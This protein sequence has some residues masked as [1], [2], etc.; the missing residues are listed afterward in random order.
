MN[1]TSTTIERF[2]PT[3]W[4]VKPLKE[5]AAFEKG[6]VVATQP[7]SGTGLI[8]YIGADS[9]GGSFTQ[10]T[11]DTAATMCE[12]SDVLM[13]WDGERSGLCANRLKGAIGSTVARLRPRGGVNGRFLY[14]QLAQHFDWIQA[15]RTGTGVPHVPKDLATLLYVSLPNDETEQARIALV[16]DT[17]DEAIAKTEAV[18]A[19]L[20]QVRAGLL[21]DLL[22]R[23]LDAHGQLR[24]PIAHPEQFQDSPLGRIPKEWKT[25]LLGQIST[26]QTGDK[27]T[28]DRVD[29]GLYPFYVRSDV[30]E[31]LNSFTFDCEAILTAGDGVGVGKVIHYATG[32]FD[33]HQRVYCIHSFPAHVC[34]RFLYYYFKENFGRRVAGMSA[35]NSVDSV[36]MNMI[37]DMPV[38]VPP[39]PEQETIANVLADADMCI[40]R[41]GAELTKL[42][43]LK[44]GLMTDLLTGRVRVPATIEL[45]AA[46]ANGAPSNQPGA[47]PQVSERQFGKG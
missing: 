12:P 47:T 3:D 31:R 24:D 10:F 32:K 15:R 33:C 29:E 22:T 6:R 16:L 4:I 38:P 25:N 26:I 19:K 45:A 11:T 20:R 8:P 46:S 27:D 41:E 42:H 5:L 40:E 43:Q 13:L 18:I 7:D 9:F 28:Q 2:I 39:R 17:V 37:S 44:S 1:A 35:K 34:G 23:G 30:V 14:Y 36:R 21:H